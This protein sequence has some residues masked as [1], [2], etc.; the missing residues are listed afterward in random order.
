MEI[1]GN[2]FAREAFNELG[3][4]KISGI[5]EYES[6]LLQKYKNE[7]ASKVKE[8]LE[9]EDLKNGKIVPTNNTNSTNNTNGKIENKKDNENKKNNVDIPQTSTIEKKDE[10]REGQKFTDLKIESK[11][12]SS[13]TKKPETK[14]SKTSKIKK[15]DFD[16]DF[17]SFNDINFSNF[18]N[19]NTKNDDKDDKKDDPFG[20]INDKNEDRNDY[21]NNTNGNYLNEKENKND[22]EYL[23][24]DNKIVLTDKMRQEADKKF[25]NKKAVGWEDYANL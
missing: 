15:V 4:P 14:I 10:G 12:K 7:L 25:A 3:I 24:R 18:E 11:E 16:F 22:T 6:N 5:F 1:T 21:N 23:S 17:D 2:K 8:L 20:S 19:S 13:V 9:L